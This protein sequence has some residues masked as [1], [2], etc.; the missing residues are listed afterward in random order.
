MKP[1]LAS[2][3]QSLE[4]SFFLIALR[5]YPHAFL[6][7]ASAIESGLQAAA[8]GATD[9][10]GLKD[11]LKKARNAS[12]RIDEFGDEPLDRFRDARNRITHRGFSPQDDDETTGLYLEIG[13]PLLRLCYSEF[14]GFDLVGGLLEE[15]ANHL[16]IAE[17]VSALVMRVPDLDRSYCLHSFG[18]LIRWAWK[19]KFSANWEISALIDAENR[20]GKFHVTSGEREK[21]ER[22]SNAPWSFCCPVCDGVDSVVA[23]LD[24]AALDLK[25][26][27]PLSMACMECGL[28]VSKS[29]LYLSQVLL[30]EQITEPVKASVFREYGIR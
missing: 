18:H 24:S 26:V 21:L 11:L 7:C 25:K 29:Q 15:Y 10:D 5:R 22:L 19:E 28:V 13:L 16:G 12:K 8:V 30:E 1:P 14:F 17:R 20:G 2:S 27:T 23:D 4:T 6:V 3:M 9:R